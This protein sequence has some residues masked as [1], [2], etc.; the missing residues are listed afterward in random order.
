[1]SGHQGGGALQFADVCEVDEGGLL[2]S[3]P[4]HLRRLHD[5]LLLLP[6][7][8]GGVLLSHDVEHSLQQLT[9]KHTSMHTDMHTQESV[10][11]NTSI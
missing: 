9:H 3:H 7:N 1:M 5:Q 6:S 4:H 8:H 10:F 2:C 11:K